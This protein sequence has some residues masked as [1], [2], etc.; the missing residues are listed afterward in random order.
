MCEYHIAVAI[1]PLAPFKACVH[2]YAGAHT[3]ATRLRF[4]TGLL[5]RAS[6]CM[7]WWIRQMMRYVL[8]VVCVKIMSY[9]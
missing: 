8:Y 6:W 5:P 3:H 9:I 4:C 2:V 7:R 1:K